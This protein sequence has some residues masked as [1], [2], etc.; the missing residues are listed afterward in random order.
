MRHLRTIKDNY[1]KDRERFNKLVSTVLNAPNGSQRLV[2]Q[3]QF[4]TCVL[5]RPRTCAGE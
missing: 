3:Q 1:I 4:H 2:M 5:K